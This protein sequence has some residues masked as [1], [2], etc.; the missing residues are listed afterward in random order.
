MPGDTTTKRVAGQLYKLLTDKRSLPTATDDFQPLDGEFVRLMSGF[1]YD[2]T[3][4]F[5]EIVDAI[6]HCDAYGLGESPFDADILYKI[7][8]N[9]NHRLFYTGFERHELDY[10]ALGK[11]FV[12]RHGGQ[13]NVATRRTS[14]NISSSARLFHRWRRGLFTFTPG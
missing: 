13:G 5:P 9:G 7:D 3:K 8:A 1:D 6:W 12:M 11:E 2:Y 10:D 14:T 4:N